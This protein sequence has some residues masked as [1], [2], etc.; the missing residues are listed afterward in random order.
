MLN[1]R[2]FKQ[3]LDSFYRIKMDPQK[4]MYP[5]DA[6]KE[7]INDAITDICS[8]T[9]VLEE[10]VEQ[11][12][13]ANR[14]EYLLPFEILK[15]VRLTFDGDSNP[16]HEKTFEDLD[17]IYDGTLDRE[18]SATPKYFVIFKNTLFLTPP[19]DSAGK[20]IKLYS[21]RLHTKLVN[22]DDAV[23]V[24]IDRYNKAI[25]QFCVWRANER[26]GNTDAA[27][28]AYALYERFREEVNKGKF[29]KMLGPKRMRTVEEMSSDFY[30]N[31]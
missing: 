6:V 11:V 26:A 5:E 15:P 23:H 28:G 12:S 7:W 1:T 22:P 2:T 24:K 13:V 25:L 21:R 14:G 3:Y 4:K 29:P 27:T 30:I 17:A 19:C 31:D 18:L 16:L 8:Y 20:I 10:I 9:G